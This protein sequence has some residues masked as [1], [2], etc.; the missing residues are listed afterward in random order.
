M[1]DLEV[2][3]LRSDSEPLLLSHCRSIAQSTEEQ[4]IV[5]VCDTT[6]SVC[7]QG[8]VVCVLKGL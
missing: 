5:P 3:G 2:V 4:D 8:T 6:C 1:S 7:T